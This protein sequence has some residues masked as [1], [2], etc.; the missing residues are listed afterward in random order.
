MSL[1]LL[2]ENGKGNTQGECR[3]LDRLHVLA[4]GGD[5]LLLQRLLQYGAAMADRF[6]TFQP[7]SDLFANPAQNSFGSGGYVIHGE[8]FKF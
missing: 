3:C 7:P 1:V 6:M 8:N 4:V 2:Q 5:I